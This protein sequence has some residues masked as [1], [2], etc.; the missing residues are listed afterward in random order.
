M[1]LA[2]D[3]FVDVVCPWCWIGERRL[4]LALQLW[5]ARHP[6][7]P[8][9]RLRFLPF[10]LNP[11]LPAEGVERR[12]YLE[13]K[14]GPGAGAEMYARVEEAGR[15]LGLAFDFA[16][17]RHQPSTRPAHV[18]LQGA[19][20]QPMLQHALLQ[21]FM[22]AFFT[23][24]AD[25][26]DPATLVRLAAQAGLPEATAR[27]W[28]ADPQLASRTTAIEMQ[29]RT[30]GISGVPFFIIERRVGVSG[31]QA[32]EDLLA[33]IEQAGAPAVG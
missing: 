3:V 27:A 2:I 33:A 15:E 14:F 21:S 9:P 7:A 17:I 31:A 26:G 28:L 18:L 32:P 10:E 23:Q 16:A 20:E 30:L 24:G 8:E 5:R 19:I 25:L 1:S 22:H 13:R 6:A 12:A 29:A 4:A 11:D